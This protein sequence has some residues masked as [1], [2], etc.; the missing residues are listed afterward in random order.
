MSR[1]QVEDIDVMLRRMTPD[2]RL[3]LPGMSPGREDIMPWALKILLGAMTYCR[4]ESVTVYDRDLL[5][6]A[7]WADS[8]GNHSIT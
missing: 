2:E 7:I 3:A 4:R 6:G 5:Y 1:R 8:A